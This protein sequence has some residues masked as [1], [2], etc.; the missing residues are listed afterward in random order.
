MRIA[1]LQHKRE[2]TFYRKITLSIGRG[3]TF[4]RK[5]TLSIAKRE[6]LL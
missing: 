3:N 2:N 5:R 1:N 4:Y 6:H